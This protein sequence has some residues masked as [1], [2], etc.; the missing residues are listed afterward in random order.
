MIY[1]EITVNDKT[2]KLRISSRNAVALEKAIG[3]NPLNVL[4]TFGDE[5]LPSIEFIVNVL[6]ASL[7]QLEHGYTLDKCYDLYDEMIEEG[8]TIIDMIMLI[9][10][11]FK[12]SGFIPDVEEDQ[13]KK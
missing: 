6:H 2:L 7:Q 3:E 9:L 4:K 13:T 1:K 10:D 5:N 12:V 8:K 11:I